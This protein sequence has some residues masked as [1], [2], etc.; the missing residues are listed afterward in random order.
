MNQYIVLRNIRLLILLGLCIAHPVSMAASS[1][2]SRWVA[3]L[4]DHSPLL[5]EDFPKNRALSL[6]RGK[7]EPSACRLFEVEESTST[8][9]AWRLTQKS[10]DALAFQQCSTNLTKYIRTYAL[11]QHHKLVVV[12][13]EDGEGHQTWRYEFYKWSPSHSFSPIEKESVG[14]RTLRNNDFLSAQAAKFPDE[15]NDEGALYLMPDG[16]FVAEPVTWM[17]KAWIER[18]P[19]FQVVFRWK[20]GWFQQEM[21]RSGSTSE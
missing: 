14:L 20:R 21:L 12:A 13:T 4:Y 16:V 3:A 6:I 15:S 11:E 7:A 19:D 2:D 18:E 1:W 8:E 5:A 17:S 10:S 9:T